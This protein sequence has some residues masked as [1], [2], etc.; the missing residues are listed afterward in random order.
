MQFKTLLINTR[1]YKI[2]WCSE[3]HI[4]AEVY[5]ILN[6]GKHQRYV[7]QVHNNKL[8]LFRKSCFTFESNVSIQLT[9]RFL[10]STIVEA[11]TLWFFEPIKS[12]EVLQYIS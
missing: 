4:F 2:L 10:N 8:P 5:I 9:H 12:V 7:P 11:G 3:T 6:D 1:N